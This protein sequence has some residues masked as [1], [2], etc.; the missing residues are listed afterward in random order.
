MI[1]G[2]IIA[3]ALFFMALLYLWGK[4]MQVQRNKALSQ[5][6]IQ[7]N[8]IEQWKKDNQ[9]YQQRIQQLAQ[10]QKIAL[11]QRDKQIYSLQ[12]ERIAPTCEA[13][14][15]WGIQKAKSL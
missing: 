15:Q 4:D 6:T 3:L 7:N 11:E 8:S 5:I 2:S 13:A 14:I 10:E 1:S 12:Q 9:D